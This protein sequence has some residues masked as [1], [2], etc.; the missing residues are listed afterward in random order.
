MMEQ[1][2]ERYSFQQI[3]KVIGVPVQDLERMRRNQGMIW[4]PKGYTLEQ[5]KQMTGGCRLRDRREMAGC[6]S[7]KALALYDLLDGERVSV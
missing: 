3:S 5:V 6:R 1:T 2:V 4:D 7:R